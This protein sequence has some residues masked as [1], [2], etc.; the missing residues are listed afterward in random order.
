MAVGVRRV[1]PQPEQPGQL[2]SLM[3]LVG[4]AAAIAG[5]VATGGASGALMAGSGGLQG[6]SNLQKMNQ[7][8]QQS[9]ID[10]RIETLNQD[11]IAQLQQAQGLVA[12]FDDRWR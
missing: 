2:D 6:L 3:G 5:G 1:T 8:P 4:P 11:P 10:R 9:P 12:S 7:G